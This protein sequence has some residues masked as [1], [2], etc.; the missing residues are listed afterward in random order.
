MLELIL[1]L[2]RYHFLAG[3]IVIQ[4]R[5]IEKNIRKN[6]NKIIEESSL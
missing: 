3:C 1:Y 6:R 4:G 2:L 5:F